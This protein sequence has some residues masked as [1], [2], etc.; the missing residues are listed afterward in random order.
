MKTALAEL[1]DRLMTRRKRVPDLIE[2][3]REARGNPFPKWM[4][5]R[6]IV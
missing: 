6:G 1:L 3:A 2:A 4:T 5:A